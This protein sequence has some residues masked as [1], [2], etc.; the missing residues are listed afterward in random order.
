MRLRE[1]ILDVVFFVAFLAQLTARA[2]DW[3]FGSNWTVVVV[4]VTVPVLVVCTVMAVY[5]MRWGR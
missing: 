2:L 3:C 5:F 1:R 4:C